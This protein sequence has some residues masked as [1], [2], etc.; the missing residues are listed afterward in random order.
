MGG[1][2]ISGSGAV[3]GTI[4][5]AGAFFFLAFAFRLIVRFAFFFAPFFALRLAKQEHRHIVEVEMVIKLP[6]SFRGRTKNRS[7]LTRRLEA[8]FLSPAYVLRF[9][10]RLTFK[11]I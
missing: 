8:V 2:T 1:A 4:A 6:G 7:R 3:S 5:G 11:E 10:A 9:R